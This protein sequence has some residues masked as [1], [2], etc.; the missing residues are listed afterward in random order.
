MVRLISA[1]LA[2]VVV[3]LVRT[4]PWL[5]DDGVSVRITVA[6]PVGHLDV[7]LHPPDA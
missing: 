2:L 6:A 7:R 5:D 3:G 1:T 4:A